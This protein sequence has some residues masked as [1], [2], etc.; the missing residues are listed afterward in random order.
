MNHEVLDNH[1]VGSAKLSAKL[2]ANGIERARPNPRRLGL[3][4]RVEAD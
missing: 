3:I 4:T 2:L 1:K